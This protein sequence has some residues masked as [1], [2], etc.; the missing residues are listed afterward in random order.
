MLLRRI[1]ILLCTSPKVNVIFTLSEEQ[2]GCP[3][4]KYKKTKDYYYI[5]VPCD[6]KFPFLCIHEKKYTGRT[7]HNQPWKLT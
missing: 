2:T 5:A 4:A 7:S 1:C 6:M 3:V